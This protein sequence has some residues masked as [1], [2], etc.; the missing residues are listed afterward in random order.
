MLRQQLVLFVALALSGATWAA[1]SEGALPPKEDRDLAH[2]ILRELV[3]INSTHEYGS[4]EIAKV[5]QKQLLSAGFAPEDVTFLAPAGKPLNGN[6]VVRYR[7]RAQAEGAFPV[8]PG[9]SR[10]GGGRRE[11][12]SMDPF[13]LTEKDGWFYGRG[14][15]DMKDGDAAMLETLIR[16]KREHFVP[17]RDLIIAFTADE[18]AGGDANGPAFLL[19]QHRDLIDA[20][21]AINLDGGGGALKNGQRLFFRLGTSEKVYGNL[22]G[23]DHEPGWTRLL[24]RA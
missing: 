4:T 3:A 23:R 21:L 13:Q 17:A 24:T 22:Y 16:L 11:D 12:W 8:V 15:L 5:I 7:A 1:G 10:C 20:G 14:T 18:E 9:P 2:D 6:V 19:E